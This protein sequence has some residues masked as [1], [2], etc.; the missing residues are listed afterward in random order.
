MA[1]LFIDGFDHS[2]SITEKGWTAATG[3]AGGFSQY[4]TTAGNYRTGSR[5]LLVY[6]NANTSV[7]YCYRTIPTGSGFRIGFG[8]K[9]YSTTPNTVFYGLAELQDGSTG[10]VSLRINTDQTL[11][12]VRG[13]PG[14]TV[15]GTTTNPITLSAFVHI[16]WQ[17]GIGSSAN[18]ELFVDGTSVI[19][20]TG[21]NTQAT[22]N[23]QATR[24]LLGTTTNVGANF[25]AFY[26]DLVIADASQPRL[27]SVQVETLYADAEGTSSDWVRSAAYGPNEAITGAGTAT[28]S[29]IAAG[30]PAANAF[31]SNDLTYFESSTIGAIGNY[32]AFDFGAAKTINAYRF[33][34]SSSSS[35]R[36]AFN[37]DGS[38]DGT[39]WTTIFASGTP[40]ETVGPTTLGSPVSYRYYRIIL[41]AN[42]PSLQWRVFSMDLFG[43]SS[44]TYHMIN[45]KV[46][47][48]D[49]TYVS[50]AT[51]GAVSVWSL[52]NLTGTGVS[53]AGIAI[54]AVAR[55]DTAGTNPLQAVVRTGSTNYTSTSTNLTSAYLNVQKIWDT[56]PNTS[57]AWTESEVNG[58]AAGIKKP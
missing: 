17:V 57:A 15:L 36:A 46:A 9:P 12:I 27:G 10:Q 48:G 38:N 20:L 19:A 49:S 39:T 53:V 14:G 50:T 7:S 43:N 1:I 37:F 42:A 2:A 51:S 18:T 21:V 26:D 52:G 11:S 35:R 5:S 3:S 30:Q 13:G 41:T 22:A 55:D 58:L 25:G 28:S 32:V 31:D 33:L 24:F 16:E 40:A 29:T 23:A 45:E 4:D 34:F 54:N 8:L 56:N 6:R 47:N 44:V